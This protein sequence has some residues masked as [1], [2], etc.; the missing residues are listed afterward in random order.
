M[1]TF[2]VPRPPSLLA[3]PLSPCSRFPQLRLHPRALSARALQ[4]ALAVKNPPA[5]VGGVGD[6]GLIS[7][8]GR[9]PGGG[10]GNPLQHPCLGNLMNRGA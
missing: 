6:A 10:H 5:N 1:P 8:S 3:R 4:M 9:S 2:Q 7:R